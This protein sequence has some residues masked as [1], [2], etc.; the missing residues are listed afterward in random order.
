VADAPRADTTA[1]GE[2]TYQNPV[3]PGD[4]A[5][6]SVVRV[7]ED[8]WATATSSEWAPLFPLLHSTNLVDWEIRGHVFP[9]HLPDWAEAHFWA[10]EIEYEA[11]TYYIYYTAK[12]KG[13]NLCVGVASATNPTGPYTDLGPL[14]C[15]EVGSIDGFAIRDER[16]DLF[17]IWKED[18]NSRGLPT[19]MWGQR[20]NDARTELLGEPFELFRNEPNSWEGGLVEGAYILRQGDYYYCFYSGDA[21]CGRGCTYGVGVAR[22]TGLQGPWEKHS[23]N[24]IMKQNEEWKCAGHG[25]VVTDPQGEHYFLYHAYSTEGGVYTGRE[26]LLDKIHWGDDGWPYF[27]EGA[28]SSR[29]P[30]PHGQHTPDHLAVEENFSAAQLSQGWQWPVDRTAAFYT[31]ATSGQEGQ[32]VLQA[33]PDRLGNLLAQRT[34]APAYTVTTAVDKRGLQQGALAGLAAIGDQENALGISVGAESIQ[35]W[36]VEQGKQET[37]A[38]VSSPAQELIQLRLVAEQGDRMALSWSADGTN[39]QVLTKESLDASYLPP[40]DRAVRVG[41]TARGPAGATVAFNWFRYAP[42]TPTARPEN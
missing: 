42:A 33:L 5:D 27:D 29:A 7:G 20:M 35:V 32:I 31:L 25:S 37:L 4:F 22:A 1:A 34:T 26:G 23:A 30:A 36:R 2:I 21:C 11:G 18:G 40:W 8:Y 12:K 13:G 14:V 28:P 16:G 3:L 10:P 41:L 24:P 19:P 39:W 17:L 9:D 38:Q 6:P 15:Q